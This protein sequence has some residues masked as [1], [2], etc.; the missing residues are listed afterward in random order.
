[1]LLPPNTTALIQ[2]INQGVLESL[3]RRYR[4]SLLRKLLLLDQGDDSMIDFVK[5][6]NVK[7]AVYMT[8]GAWDD[9]PSL[10]LSKSWLK[11]LGTGHGI[12]ETSDDN[13]EDKHVRSLQSS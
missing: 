12:T 9:I 1:M 10:T 3:K 8:A 2:P 4:K 6:I 5:K 13:A 7:D 11:L